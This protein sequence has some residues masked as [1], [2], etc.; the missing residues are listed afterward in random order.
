MMGTISS[1]GATSPT[2]DLVKSNHIRYNQSIPNHTQTATPLDKQTF[3][4][5]ED[6]MSNQYKQSNPKRKKKSVHSSNPSGVTIFHHHHY[7]AADKSAQTGG[8][9]SSSLIKNE[10]PF[11]HHPT[12][13]KV[14]IEKRKSKA[15]NGVQCVVVKEEIASLHANDDTK[16]EIG[17]EDGFTWWSWY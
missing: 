13:N 5:V 12:S 4:F 10:N 16:Y 17:L 3:V 1:N 15:K 8:S 11:I 14:K 2:T 6:K 7:Q 9:S